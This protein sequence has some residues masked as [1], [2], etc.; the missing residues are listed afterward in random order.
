M[1]SDDGAAPPA[2][3]GYA[4]GRAKRQEIIETAMRIFGEQGFSE[5]SMVEIAEQCSLS[6]AGLHHHFPSKASILSAVLEWRDTKDRDR[7]RANGSAGADGLGVLRGMVDLAAHNAHVPGLIGLYVRV[8]AEAAAPDHPSHDY[9]VARYQRI[10]R[11]TARTLA[12]VRAAGLLADGV[13]DEAAATS[14]TAVMDGLQLQWLLQP[15]AIDMPGELTRSIE[16]LLTVPLF[17]QDHPG[18][19]STR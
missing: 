4:K 5:A 17:D 2:R 3:R 12:K 15:D 1:S 6:R 19:A 10:R 14:L 7:F 13:D 8:A 16:A 18:P 9:F 11:E